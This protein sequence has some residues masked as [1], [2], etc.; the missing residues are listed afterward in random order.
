[1][2]LE[3]LSSNTDMC[4]LLK[5]KLQLTHIPRLWGQVLV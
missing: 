1:M 5:N 4:N 3:V 2:P